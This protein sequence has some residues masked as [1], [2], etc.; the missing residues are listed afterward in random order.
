MKHKHKM[1]RLEA[2][3]RDFERMKQG[4]KDMS[5]YHCPGSQKK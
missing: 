5:G 1:E 2:R 3:R 4:N